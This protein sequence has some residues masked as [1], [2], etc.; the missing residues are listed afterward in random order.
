[1]EEVVETNSGNYERERVPEKDRKRWL[2]ISMVWIAIG[3][4]LSGMFMGVAL[5]QGMAFWTAIAAVAIGSII[6]GVLAIG[7]TY[8]GAKAGLST[9]MIS[10]I[11]FGK[12]GASL[13][14]A[15]M[16]ISSLGWFGVQIGFFAENIGSAISQLTS[17][18]VPS[19]LLSLI[20]GGLMML[21]AFWG[22]QA[23]EKLCTY[24]V[25]LLAALIIIATIMSINKNGA[26][27]LAIPPQASTISF[28]LA[29]S[30][31]IGVYMVGVVMAPDVA[32]WAQNPKQAMIAGFV[33]FTIGNSFMIIISL[34]LVKVMKTAD[35]TAVFFALGLG[36]PSILVLTLAQWTTNTNNLYSASLDFSIVFK[37]VNPKVITVICGSLGILMAMFGIYGM[38]ENFLSIVTVL[39]SPIAGIYM[40][41]Y[42]LYKEKYEFSYEEKLQ[43]YYPVSIIYWVIG[44]TVAFMTSQPPAGFGLF[45]LTN[46][47]AL[48]G[49]IVA[50][51]C[52][53]VL[54]KLTKGRK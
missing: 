42:F 22:Y 14:G 52:Y 20:G 47:S 23:I 51:I 11:S 48:D 16:G 32:R 46:I 7:T 53:F 24:S 13:M 54:T 33:G 4:D 38:F 29:V 39:V 37:R 12:K 3:I 5:S 21:S 9:G 28:G 27:G 18:T 2:S 26:S 25:P 44:S 45:T 35:L 41:D 43:D 17:T 31:V 50:G 10:R 15:I 40:I 8:I 19:W 1:M 36:I 30:L 34:I 6:L 49:I